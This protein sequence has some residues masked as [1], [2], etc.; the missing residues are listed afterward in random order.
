M[1]PRTRLDPVIKLEEQKEERRLAEL[2]AAGRQV[3]SAEQHLRDAR[4]RA[5]ADHR[6]AAT[7]IDWQLT[8]L[9]H[10]RALVDVHNAERAVVQAHL[11]ATTSREAYRAVHSKAEALRRVAAVRV[12]EI[13]MTRA[14]AEAKELD[15]QGVLAFNI[16]P[17]AA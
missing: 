13:L 2:A 8:E 5:S 1:R 12:D 17:R 7:A 9:A 3:R 15:E 4:S 16:R 6:R 10:A 14:K 11:A